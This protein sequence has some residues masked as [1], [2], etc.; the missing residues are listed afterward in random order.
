MERPTALSLTSQQQLGLDHFA[1][2]G[3]FPRHM[4]ARAAERFAWVKKIELSPQYHAVAVA[5]FHL[6]LQGDPVEVRVEG[7]GKELHG[8]AL[9]LSDAH[10]SGFATERRKA[11]GELLAEWAIPHEAKEAHAI[12]ADLARLLVALLLRWHRAEQ[13][14][15]VVST[16]V[17]L[18]EGARR[19][20]AGFEDVLFGL[21]MTVRIAMA[22][23]LPEVVT[24]GCG[25]RC[26]RWRRELWP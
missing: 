16:V 25:G 5:C 24:M 19:Y 10:R 21:P 6:Q 23:W 13:K 14:T 1:E 18:A 17:A 20:V 2:T 11:E 22:G 12:Q 9:L 8:P 15:N 26:V 7:A 3:A 4:A